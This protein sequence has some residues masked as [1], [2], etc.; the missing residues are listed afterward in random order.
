MD[1]SARIERKT[2]ETNITVSL[3][4]DGSGKAEI[5]TG[6]GFFDHMMTSFALHGGFDLELTVKGDLFV[7]GHHTVEDSGIAIGMAFDEALG[8]RVGISRFASAFV[9]MDEALS[10]AA[11]D[12]GGRP[13]FKFEA[14][15]PV[16]MMGEYDSQ[17]TVEFMRALCFN[18]KSTLHIKNI[19]GD[20]AHHMTESIYKC[21]ARALKE[22]VSISGA[23]GAPSTKGV[24]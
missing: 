12:I 19:Y 6:I 5:N 3:N 11:I 10:F 22:G 4:L 2:R 9:P 8:Q 21:V 18:M 7:D 15:I 24:I 16:C 17:M 23:D 1:R 13:Y 14:E 20:N